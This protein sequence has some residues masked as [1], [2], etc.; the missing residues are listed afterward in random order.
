MKT[1]FSSEK[2]RVPVKSWCEEPEFSALEQAINASR[3][4][5]AFS[6]IALMPDTHQGFGLPIGGVAALEEAVSPNMV[7][8]DIACGMMAVKLDI[9]VNELQREQFQS[10]MSRIQK[11][12]PMGFSHQKDASLYKSE[13]KNIH[14]K[15]CDKI[16]DA[17]DL[18]LISPEIVSGQ[19]GTLGGGNHFIEIQSDENGIVWAMIHSGSRNI[20]KQVCE[21]YNQKARD[22]NAKYSVKLPSKD[23]AFL[24][25][26]TKEFETYLALMNFCVDFSY[27]NR[28]C[29]MK[30]ILEAFNDITKKNLNVVSKINIHHNYASLE[31]HFGRKVWVHRKGAINADKG[32]M[33]IIPGSMGTCSYI[34]EGRGCEDSFKS[35]SHGAGRVMSRSAAKKAFSLKQFQKAMGDIVF[36]CEKRFIDEAPMAYKKI[37]KVMSEQKDLVKIIHKLTPLA[38]EKG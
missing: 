20:G 22:L 26:G 1:I 31:E 38:V 6:H 7:G 5:A 32:I 14:N 17:E 9:S 28:E 2:Q 4:P 35:S 25:G 23:L 33:G 15:H 16:K 3:H 24:P 8:V 21:K 10:I 11:L 30:R 37:E 12:I 13:A 29:M 27:M 18:K 19:L 34:V 36:T